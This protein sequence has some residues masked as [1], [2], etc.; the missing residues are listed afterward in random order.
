MLTDLDLKS[1]FYSYNYYGIDYGDK[2]YTYL[3]NFI[4]QKNQIV[5]FFYIQPKGNS[6]TT[7]SL[8]KF[9]CFPT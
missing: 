8:V 9:K 5:R 6:K 2:L 4:W 3:I 7:V 1:V